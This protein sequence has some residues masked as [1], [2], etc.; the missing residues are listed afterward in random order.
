MF[1]FFGSNSL[2][3]IAP[4]LAEY[5][6]KAEKPMRL[7]ISPNLSEADAQALRD[8]IKT[9]KL[10]L[11]ERLVELVGEPKVSANA[12][13]QHTLTC[14]AYLLAN[15]KIKIRVAWLRDG[16]LFHS[17]VWLFQ[18]DVDTVSVHGS[19]NLTEPGLWRNHEQIRVDASWQGEHAVDS[20]SALKREFEELWS[21][22]SGYVIAIDLPEVV[23]NK[24]LRE[25]T[26]DRPPTQADFENAWAEDVNKLNEL[27][28][29]SIPG[30]QVESSS[31][32]IPDY[33][34]LFEGAFA[35][36]G[37]ALTK[38]EQAGRR[39]ILA[40]A[41][42]SG[43][44]IT[45]LAAATRLQED[46][47]S[48]LVIVSAPY[49]PLVAQW[50]QE[51]QK[52]GVAPLPATGSAEKKANSL[53]LAVRG[54]SGGVSQVEVMVVTEDFLTSPKFRAVLD[55]IPDS[56][57]TLLIADEVHNLGKLS[58]IN[59]LPERFDFRLGLSATPERQYDPDGTR[60]LFDFFGDPVFEFTLKEA[61]N[62]CLVPYNYYMYQVPLTDEEYE[63]WLA[64][65]EILRKIGVLSDLDTSDSPKM[66]KNAE[67]L[68]FKRRRII[69]SA[70]AKIPMLRQ[71]LGQRDKDEIKHA[72]VY[73]TDKNREQL[74]EVNRMLQH[75]LGLVIH[76]VT[77]RQ[78]SQ[79][80]IAPDILRRFAEGEYNA[81]TCM[82]VLDE[83]VDV[84]QVSEA[85]LLASNTVKRQWIQRRGRVLRKCDAI[86]KKIAHLHD[87]I[88]IPPNPSDSAARSLLNSE[89]QRAHEFAELAENGGEPGG[90]FEQLNELME[91]MF[92]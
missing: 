69:E 50:L 55:A 18:D 41:T 39:G 2:R 87:F 66:E 91:K 44:T 86:G 90:S 5:H 21:G 68:L 15:E 14:L 70:Q 60:V 80:K 36:Q 3:A 43:K 16:G 77:A 46:V 54:L 19:S 84:P 8:G 53:D 31:L 59:D 51:V 34:N 83:G 28:G 20:I 6:L 23:K 56:V 30:A 65:T 1:G 17:K 25:Y 35:H 49:K 63:D 73:A 29:S 12:L 74:I 61:I 88:V 42:G 7:I 32:S 85:F 62:V 81:L 26:P 57:R 9:P 13:A 4:G 38:W 11:E 27:F 47:D 76:E 78:T 33:L 48:L 40:M 10:A 72:L 75:D 22:T 71:I 58:F 82:R 79:G 37:R 24:L 52:F 64:L 89:I 67:M 45:A 92:N